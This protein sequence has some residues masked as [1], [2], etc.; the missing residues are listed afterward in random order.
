MF[1]LHH[2]WPNQLLRE[3]IITFIHRYAQSFDLFAFIFIFKLHLSPASLTKATS[4]FIS[5]LK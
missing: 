3:S 5:S 4:I 1:E 2:S